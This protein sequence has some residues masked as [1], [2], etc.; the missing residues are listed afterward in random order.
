MA[1][2]THTQWEGSVAL[3]RLAIIGAGHVGIVYAAGLAEFGHDVSLVDINEERVRRLQGGAIWFREPD[4]PELF[5]KGLRE[6]RIAVTTSYG[7][8]LRETEFAL[9]CVPTPMTADGSL[10][11][12]YVRAAADSVVQ[13]SDD[14]HRPIL[15]NKSTVPVGTGA[16][17]ASLL[18]ER[19]LLVASNPEFLAEGRAVRDF[20][21]PA[22]IVIGSESRD[23]AERVAS[24]FALLDAP[25]VI[26]DLITAEL[27]KLSSNAFLATKISF[28]NSVAEIGR[29][30]GADV[31]ALIDGIALDPRIGR[32]HMLPGIGYGGSC[33]PKDLAGLEQVARKVGAPYELLAAAGSINRAQRARVVEHLRDRIGALDHARVAV[34]GAAYKPLT[35][36]LRDSPGLALARDLID[37]HVSVSIWDP[38]ADPEEIVAALPGTAIVPSALEAATGAD[39]IVIATDWSELRKLDLAEVARVMRGRLLV[40]GRGV[41]SRTD[42]V[43]AGLDYYGLGKP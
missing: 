29:R 19:G 24:L 10:D 39:A 3:S 41:C 23:V 15:V 35:D 28:A 12:S 7:E 2:V 36:D 16:A 31:A 4:L 1:S 34:L 25:I 38:W 26:T 9:L 40:D 33:L 8:A 17:T 13:H 11:D 30:L 18:R 37:L 27:I 43:A 5:G 22:R 32:A 6:G 14:R 20:F 21:H 42:A